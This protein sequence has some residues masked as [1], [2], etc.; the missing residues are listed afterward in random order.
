MYKLKKMW[1]NIFPSTKSVFFECKENA[2]MLRQNYYKVIN[3]CFILKKLIY[4]VNF[5]SLINDNTFFLLE[6]IVKK[7]FAAKYKG[8]VLGICRYH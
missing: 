3:F 2:T 8:S 5:M 4:N 6:E 1:Y 7:N